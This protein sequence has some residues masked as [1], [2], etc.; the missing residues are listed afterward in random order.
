MMFY[1][2]KYKN[3]KYEVEI[4]IKIEINTY[5]IIYVIKFVCIFFIMNSI[6]T[7]INFFMIFL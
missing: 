3:I 1:L 4:K 5:N 7:V 6:I 2:K